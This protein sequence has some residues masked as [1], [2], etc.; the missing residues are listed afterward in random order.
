MNSADARPMLAAESLLLME[1]LER[2]V[3]GIDGA[4]IQ[5][6]PSSARISTKC[7]DSFDIWVGFDA[8]GFAVK[9][10]SAVLEGLRREQALEF[11]EEALEGK[12][13]I[14]V[15]AVGGKPWQ[16]TVE[17]L[18]PNGQWAAESVTGRIAF[19]WW[20]QETTAYK[21]NVPASE[22]AWLDAGKARSAEPIV[23]P[24]PRVLEPTFS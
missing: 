11:V 10:D 14:K 2:L 19:R 13:R 21:L 3:A 24:R 6:G 17:R 23:S 4:E 9:L 18:A 5:R 1:A 8:Q 7:S 22:Q 15:D 16:W 20:R 12:I